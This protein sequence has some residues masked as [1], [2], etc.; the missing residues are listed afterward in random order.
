MRAFLLCVTALTIS[1]SFDYFTFA[2]LSILFAKDKVS[3]L[4]TWSFFSF[5][6]IKFSSIFIYVVNYPF[7]YYA[8]LYSF[9]F[10]IYFFVFKSK[11]KI[12]LNYLQYAVSSI[13]FVVVITFLSYAYYKIIMLDN[14]Y[15]EFNFFIAILISTLLLTSLLFTVTLIRKK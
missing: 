14:D 11:F 9:L 4:L 5:S 6:L 2:M 7:L 12:R 1:Y 13:L 3:F 10:F 8:T 15:F